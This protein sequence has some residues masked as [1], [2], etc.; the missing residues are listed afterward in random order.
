MIHR[1]ARAALLLAALLLLALNGCSTTPKA[2][3]GRIRTFANKGYQ[4]DEQLPIDSSRSQWQL[5]NGPNDVAIAAPGR[6]GRY[7]LVL[8][9]PGLG[10]DSGAGEIWRSAWAHNGYAVVSIQPLPVDRAPITRPNSRLR[11]LGPLVRERYAGETVAARVVVLQALVDEIARRAEGGDALCQRIDLDRVIVAGYDIGA[12]TAMVLAGEHPMGPDQ[13]LTRA[14]VRAAIALSPYATFSGTTFSSRYTEIK[15]PVLSITSDVD[16]DP[17]GLVSS[18]SVRGAPYRYMPP[19]NKYLLTFSGL[20]RL[21]LSGSSLSEED[22]QPPK[23]EDE[24]TKRVE[25]AAKTR[26]DSIAG[27]GGPSNV[28]RL[29][30]PTTRGIDAVALL[31]VSIAF[32]DTQIKNDSIAREW[33]EKNAASWIADRGTLV[34]R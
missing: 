26:S 9:M 33:L 24:D 1:F 15:V 13:A 12:Y 10:Q 32:M 14:H 31:S 16:A 11:D 34:R 29:L 3:E 25:K 4:S 19:Q 28:D 5:S 20:P 21:V 22:L 6:P 17:Y 18:P 30:D 7:P 8:F 23:D 27:R 2:D